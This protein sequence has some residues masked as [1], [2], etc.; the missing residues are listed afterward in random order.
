MILDPNRLPRDMDG[1][2][3]WLKKEFDKVP[4]GEMPAYYTPHPIDLI[5]ID[6]ELLRSLWAI[7]ARAGNLPG[8]S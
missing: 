7:E 8:S 4:K 5:V 2:L 6:I 1:F 3:R